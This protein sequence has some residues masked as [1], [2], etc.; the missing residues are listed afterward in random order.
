M[1]REATILLSG[2]GAFA[3]RILFDIAATATAPIRVVL[4]GRNRERLQWLK[5]A[6]GARA[7]I[8]GT[9]VTVVARET[10]LLA[11]GAALAMID[12]STPDVVV[13][14]A[15]VQTSSVIA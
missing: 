14:A 8:F 10:D 12:E 5:V 7:A 4:A 11:E 6:A 13:Q 9:P 15:S 1:T 2:T 3:A